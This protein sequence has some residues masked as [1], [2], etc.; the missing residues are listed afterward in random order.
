LGLAAI[1]VTECQIKGLEQQLQKLT[2]QKEL[3]EVHADWRETQVEEQSPMPANVDLVNGESDVTSDFPSETMEEFD[4]G[5]ADYAP[6]DPRAIKE[7]EDASKRKLAK[8]NWFGDKQIRTKY[9]GYFRHY[10]R[11][12]HKLL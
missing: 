12:E 3:E 5:G 1:S 9:R 11:D 8:M 2:V 6:D 4:G 10:L 7:V